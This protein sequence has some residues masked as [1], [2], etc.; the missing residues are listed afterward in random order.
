MGGQRRNKPTMDTYLRSPQLAYL[1]RISERE[2]VS[3]SQALGSIIETQAE[4]ASDQSSSSRKAR[5]TLTLEPAQLALLDR[6]A[7]KLGLSR[8][9]VARRLIDHAQANDPWGS[10]PVLKCADA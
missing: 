7:L 5:T 3:L 9:D 8:S 2:G 6:L 1:R 4:V 10:R